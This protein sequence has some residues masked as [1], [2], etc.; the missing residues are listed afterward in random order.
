M[1][2]IKKRKTQNDGHILHAKP[3]VC[4]LCL[5]RC[6]AD[7]EDFIDV[8]FD[9]QTQ[10]QEQG[11]PIYFAFRLNFARLVRDSVT[12]KFSAVGELTSLFQVVGLGLSVNRARASK[13]NGFLNSK[14]M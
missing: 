8:L 9:S 1:E 2:E 10:N 14:T 13:K 5:S 4:M 12:S 3:S 7:F 6:A 11:R